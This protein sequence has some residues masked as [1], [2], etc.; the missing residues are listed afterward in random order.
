MLSKTAIELLD[1]LAKKHELKRAKVL[2]LLIT[3]E[4][5]DGVY[6]TGRLKGGQENYLR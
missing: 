2:E 3:T 1:T 6:F 5:E 4:S